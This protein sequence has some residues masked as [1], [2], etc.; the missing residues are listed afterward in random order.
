MVMSKLLKQRFTFSSTRALISGGE[1]A[2]VFS[3]MV[4]C[5]STAM[6]S[7]MARLYKGVAGSAA[8]SRSSSNP[9]TINN[10]HQNNNNRLIR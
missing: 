1:G 2:T 9:S 4:C 10:I 5:F 7:R 8:T 3:K 6:S